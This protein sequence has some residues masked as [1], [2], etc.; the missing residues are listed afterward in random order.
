MSLEPEY[1]DWRSP[2]LAEPEY[3][4]RRLVESEYCRRAPSR[5]LVESEYDLWSPLESEYERLAPLEPEYGQ[6][7]RVDSEYDGRVAPESEYGRRELLSESEY[8]ARAV[9]ES[10]SGRSAASESESEYA[11][12][13]RS[14]LGIS[15]RRQL[16]SEY[17]V[18]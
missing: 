11:L 14:V 10:D 6:Q 18:R 3:R 7:P 12:P 17:S 2:G 13:R 15:R 5:L 1:W 9:V 8:D 16:E 4:R